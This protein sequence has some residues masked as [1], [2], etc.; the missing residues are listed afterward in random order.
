MDKIVNFNFLIL[1][2]FLNFIVDKFFL[3]RVE[4]NGFGYDLLV[5]GGKKNLI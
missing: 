3:W 2:M 1:I 4:I 5:I